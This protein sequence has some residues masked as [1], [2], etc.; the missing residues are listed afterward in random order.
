V[1]VLQKKYDCY[2]LSYEEQVAVDTFSAL[3]TVVEMCC[4][5]QLRAR[6]PQGASLLQRLNLLIQVHKREGLDTPE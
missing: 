4:S 3:C 1:H 6:M 2:Q 5:D